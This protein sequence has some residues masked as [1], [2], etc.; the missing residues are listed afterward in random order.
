MEK[1]YFGG[2]N[3]MGKKCKII[4]G[5]VFL[6]ITVIFFVIKCFVR[7]L[8]N[9]HMKSYIG[10]ISIADVDSLDGHEFEEFL[11]YF[12]KSLGLKVKKTKKSR[13]YGADLVLN[14]S[15]K[16]IVIQCKL[17][18]NHSVGNSAIQE[19]NTAKNYY[20]ADK[21]VVITNSFFSKSAKNLSTSAD[22]ILIDRLAFD[23]LLSADKT[24]KKLLLSSYFE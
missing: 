2:D 3:I 13:D 16:I 21:G 5:I 23:E 6:P 4:A 24:N 7:L 11:F 17:Y 8:E 9:R 20:M 15:D 12:F 18:Y 19:I 22:I 10:S 14:Y 1:I